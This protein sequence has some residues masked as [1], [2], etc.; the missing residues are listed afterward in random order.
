MITPEGLE[1]DAPSP[2]DIVTVRIRPPKV[3][4]QGRPQPGLMFGTHDWWEWENPQHYRHTT[5]WRV[6]AVNGGQAVVEAAS[7]QRDTGREVWPIALH[8][9]FEAS[10]LLEAMEGR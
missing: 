9:W 1:L 4:P 8:R 6:V 7:K 3:L 10:T 2:G 5:I